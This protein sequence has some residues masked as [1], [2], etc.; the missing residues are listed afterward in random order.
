MSFGWGAGDILAGIQLVKDVIEAIK[1]GPAE[2]QE[3]CR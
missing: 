2:Y 1:D 3:I